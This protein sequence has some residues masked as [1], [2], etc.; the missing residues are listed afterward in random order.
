ML[1]TGEHAENND[2]D[3]IFH[4]LARDYAFGFKSLKYAP[5]KFFPGE[6]TTATGGIYL[7]VM[8]S[9]TFPSWK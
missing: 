7:P 3:T 2:G 6:R 8:P 4:V 5:N 9:Y 1:T